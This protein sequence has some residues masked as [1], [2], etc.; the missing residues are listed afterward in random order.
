M[1]FAAFVGLSLGCDGGLEPT[2]AG[3][4]TSFVGVCGTVTYRGTVPDSTDL[5]F[6]VAYDTFPTSSADLFKFKPKLPPTIPAGGQPFR[7]SIPL[8]AGHYEWVV[9]VWKK[10]GNLNPDGSNADTLLRAAGFY[11]NPADTS[12]PGVVVVGTG[13]TNSIDFVVDFGHMRRICDFFPP[14][15]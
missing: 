12:Q 8:P 4:P 9:A 6:T 7:Y 15:P 3:C 1:L 14:C 11:R 13:P 10:I 2:P 5:I